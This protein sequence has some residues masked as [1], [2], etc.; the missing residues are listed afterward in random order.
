MLGIKS[1]MNCK[2]IFF[3]SVCTQLL[4]SSYDDE[5]LNMY[6]QLI[7]KCINHEVSYTSKTNESQF[8]NQQI[9]SVCTQLLTSS[10][11]DKALNMYLQLIDKCINHEV[12]YRVRMMTRLST[13]TSS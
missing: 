3:L 10:Y 6:L 8:D 2:I 7:D 9:I 1:E 11:D 12:S 5:A 13:C 4:T